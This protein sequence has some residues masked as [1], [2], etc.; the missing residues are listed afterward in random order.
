M[1]YNWFLSGAD[2]VEGA[3]NIQY[4]PDANFGSIGRV[5]YINFDVPAAAQSTF[6]HTFWTAPAVQEKRWG[7]PNQLYMNVWLAALSFICLKKQNQKVN[8]HTDKFG[9]E[10]LQFLPYDKVYLDLEGHKVSNK[11]WASGKFVAMRNEAEGAVHIDTDFFLYDGHLIDKIA[12]NDIVVSH[13]ENAVNYK[14]LIDLFNKKLNLNFENKA[15]NAG[16]LKLGSRAQRFINSYWKLMFAAVNENAITAFC[17]AND[18]DASCC[19][20]LFVEQV[21]LYDKLKDVDFVRLIADN[22]VQDNMLSDFGFAHLICFDKYVH[23]PEVIEKVKELD[24]SLYGAIVDKMKQ[25]DVS[26]E[27]RINSE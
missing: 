4:S 24:N 5:R 21:N 14:E 2:K 27:L 23:L 12:D 8:L 1:L 26:F 3:Q 9:A 7:I 18:K 6:F 11:F 16:L 20:D 22:K 15:I 25:L 17:L 19:P 10:L 13:V